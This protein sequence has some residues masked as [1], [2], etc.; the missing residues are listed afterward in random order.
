VRS[1]PIRLLA[2]VL[3]ALAL[4]AI[5]VGEAAAHVIEHPGAY[6][7]AL[8]WQH[9][10]AYVGFQN[11]V[12][13][14]ITDAAGR[15][16]AD[17]GPDDLSVVVSLA[18]QLSAPLS[19]AN[20]FDE[21]TGLGREGEYDAS[22]LPTSPGDYTFHLTGSIHGTNVDLTESSSEQ[23]FDSVVGTTDVEFPVKLP[24]MAEVTTRLDRIDARIS[25]GSD[26]VPTVASVA[27]AA[28]AAGDARDAANRA[29][30]IGGA[31][32][33]VGVLLAVLALIRGRPEARAEA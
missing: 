32:G 15:P 9:E 10:P 1:S 8:G 30:L 22:I 16:V 19:F 27:A 12:Q 26:T 28:A 23:T 4:L 13:V 24:T 33:G 3:A 2:P 29:L 5:S 14:V 20:G 7:L 25:G 31:I 17:L 6:T 21:D 18:G 11:A